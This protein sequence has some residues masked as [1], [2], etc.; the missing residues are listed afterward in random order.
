M[1]FTQSESG[2][3]AKVTLSQ[4]AGVERW[5]YYFYGSPTSATLPPN[6]FNVHV[7]SY[8]ARTING[9]ETGET[10]NITFDCEVTH[11]FDNQTE[12]MLYEQENDISISVM[13]GGDIRED[14]YSVILFRQAESGKTFEIVWTAV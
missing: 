7:T 1:T 11:D 14:T 10:I 2:K 13:T 6:Y 8:K 12:T 4:A 9:N 3:T 5:N